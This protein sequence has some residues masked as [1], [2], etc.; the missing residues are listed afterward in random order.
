VRSA[1]GLCCPGALTLS[2]TWASGYRVWDIV[3]ELVTAVTANVG[4]NVFAVDLPE[5]AK[6]PP[7]ER[8]FLSGALIQFLR[9]L[10][11]SSS[12]VQT[13]LGALTALHLS[14]VGSVF[15]SACV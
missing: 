14:A 2:L 13:D 1:A 12:A 7:A 10:G 9:E 5:V 8:A 6:L 11:S 4:G 3:G 15:H